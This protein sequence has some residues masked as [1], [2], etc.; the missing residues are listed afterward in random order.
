MAFINCL[1]LTDLRLGNPAQCSF[2]PHHHSIFYADIEALH[3][4]AGPFDLVLISGNLTD[5]GTEKQFELVTKFVEALWARLEK[6]GS[7][8]KLLTVPGERDLLLP[9]DD[10]SGVLALTSW[11]QSSRVRE[12]FW[13]SKSPLRKKVA[14]AFAPY[15]R[16]LEKCKQASTISRS[17]GLIP[18]DFSATVEANGLKLGVIS[19]N[20][21]FLGVAQ[22]KEL[23][24]DVLQ[25]NEVCSNDPPGWLE[26]RDLNLLITPH[27]CARLH[28]RSSSH[29]H[30]FIYPP[31]RFVLY[32]FGDAKE[33]PR[34]EEVGGAEMRR[35]VPGL[36]L[37]GCQPIDGVCHFGYEALR[38]ELDQGVC[39]LQIWPR[40][41][42]QNEVAQYTR[43]VP[44]NITWRLNE[45]RWSES[46]TLSR[47]NITHIQPALVPPLVLRQVIE[48]LEHI[49]DPAPLKKALQELDAQLPTDQHLTDLAQALAH[50]LL[51]PPAFTSESMKSMAQAIR[52]LGP[53]LGRERAIRL[54]E[55]ITPFR[56]VHPDASQKL[57]D[58]TQRSPLERV[59][60]INGEKLDFTGR[61][62]VC[63]AQFE[64]EKLPWI[65]VSL[66]KLTEY[67]FEEIKSQI[68]ECLK[69]AL[70]NCDSDEA[71]D[72]LLEGLEDGMELPVVIQLLAPPTLSSSVVQRLK[73]HFRTITLLLFT[74]QA[75]PPGSIE[76]IVPRLQLEQEKRAFILY[77]A[78][79]SAA[80][81]IYIP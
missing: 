62:Y 24:L 25:L 51:T 50:H 6:L 9:R 66:S 79:M 27:S 29:F 4:K 13:K 14:N 28:S 39:N 42:Q 69:R 81:G 64:E 71:V 7:K 63:R 34:F 44:N 38:I 75:N 53:H 37:F 41:A 11:H 52:W 43:F 3:R 49:K 19:L 32:L 15:T 1:H 61:Y 47:R 78:T 65:R 48:E 17:T 36:S 68:Y 77:S 58:V 20:S 40:L 45:E 80:M 73:E 74:G 18:G 5:S 46:F 23:E 76:V 35:Y 26:K 70:W 30:E 67:S 31:G 59:A 60:G 57:V 21:G 2:A 55:L 54:L 33:K 12:A 10:D 56:W 16:W 72:A 8:P 22:H